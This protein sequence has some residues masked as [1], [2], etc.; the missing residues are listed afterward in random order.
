MSDINTGF[1]NGARPNV[2]TDE[3]PADAS[4]KIVERLKAHG[5]TF[6]PVTADEIEEVNKRDFDG[7]YPYIDDL[8]SKYG[9]SIDKLGIIINKKL[10]GYSIGGLFDKDGQ[11]LGE[12]GMTHISPQMRDFGLGSTVVLVM[13]DRLMKQN[14]DALYA[15]LADGTGKMQ[16]LHERLGYEEAGTDLE[17][18]G[19]PV[20]IK[21]FASDVDKKAFSQHLEEI[22]D[23]RLSRLEENTSALNAR[24]QEV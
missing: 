10:V 1:D 22:I 21:K 12:A 15:V 4:T 11:T 9:D 7:H 20:W 23:T 3:N 16:G 24:A 2:P 6:E 17:M 18:G 8:S 19:Y 14:P 13:Y 5:I